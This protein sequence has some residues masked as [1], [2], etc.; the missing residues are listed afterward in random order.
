METDGLPPGSRVGRYQIL[1]KLGAGNMGV[2]YRAR[3][4]QLGREVAVKVLAPKLAGNREAL[5]RFQLEARAASALENPNVLTIY[6]AGSHKGSPYMVSELLVGETL[7]NRLLRGKLLPEEALR[8]AVQLA[9]GLAAAHE[10]GIVHRD[11]KPE[12]IF[13]TADQRIKI[14]D[15]GI[16]KLLP[17][18]RLLPPRQGGNPEVQTQDGTSLGTPAYMSPEQVAGRGV[19][20]RCDIFSFGSI[21]YEMLSGSRA[22]PGSGE[23]AIANAIVTVE[24]PPLRDVPLALDQ[25][26][27]RCLRKKVEERFQSGRELEQALKA[28]EGGSSVRARPDA[29]VPAMSDVAVPDTALPEQTLARSRPWLARRT[30]RIAML[31]SGL[32]AAAVLIWFLT[33]SA[34]PPSFQQITFRRGTVW[35]ARFAPEGGTVLHSAAWDGGKTQTQTTV[36]GKNASRALDLPDGRV[37][38]VSNTGELAIALDDAEP[39]LDYMRTGTL[40]RVPLAGGAPRELLT[41]VSGA[42]W[43]PR[44]GELAVLHAADGKTRVEFPPGK[45]LYVSDGWL[46]H[47]RVSPDGQIAFIEHPF[48]GDTRGVVMLIDAAGKASPL[49][50]DFGSAMGLAWSPRGDEVWV[51]AGETAQSAALLAVSAGGAQRELLKMPGSLMLQDVAR[52][53]RVLLARESWRHLIRGLA[54]GKSE[55]RDLSWQDYSLARELS[56]DGSKLLFFEAGQGGG[57]LFSAYLRGMDASAPIPL[58]PGYALSLTLDGKW[59]LLA[60][61]R[62]PSQLIVVPTGPGQSRTLSLPIAAVAEARWFPD[63][64]SIL[65]TAH[66][67]SSG[68]RRMFVVDSVSAAMRP[69]TEPGLPG[70]EFVS[71]PVSPDGKRVLVK[72]RDGYFVYPAEGAEPTRVEGLTRTQ[73]AIGWHGERGSLLVREPG[74][75]TKV[76]R[77][78]L[79]THRQQPWRSFSPADPAGVSDIPWIQFASSPAG[80]AYVY[81][82][83]QI[84]SELYVVRGIR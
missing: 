81:S 64:A 26:V 1:A 41:Q 69:V 5:H 47:V 61:V 29:Q 46:S 65:L 27:R 54:P 72:L 16:A 84:L 45:V 74:L 40:A 79:D 20:Q 2:V 22:F 82:Y 6:D 76:S 10:T 62:D 30:T 53:G 71:K 37:L 9:G 3:D 19:D 21:F 17:A 48:F 8:Y 75:P 70:Q 33:R 35:S 32:V 31:A 11:L 56:A 44:T 66:E 83:H 28:L 58:G 78:A 38:A 25:I 39:A 49:T 24:P 52:D 34:P 59:A 4:T 14:L 43:A 13:V 36:P 63:G 55:E 51:T 60:S 77:L 57:E 50:A 15:F 42:D 68:Q 73:V 12:N 67:R 18:A 7:R 23:Y 80:E